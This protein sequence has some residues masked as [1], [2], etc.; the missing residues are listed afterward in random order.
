MNFRKSVWLFSLIGLVSF[1]GVNE[2]QAQ[3]YSN[4]FT[5]AS[6]CP[7]P[8]NVP[9][10]PA[11]V[12]GSP[13]TRQGATCTVTANVF[14]STTL[15]NTATLS[16]TNY[17]EF[18]LTAN[19]GYKM[20]I[21]SLS[22]FRQGSGTAPN[23]LEVRYSTD[24]FAT[25]TAW[26]AAP[27]TPTSGSAITWNF[28]DFL[29]RHGGSVK[30]RFYPYGTQRADLAAGTAATTGTFRLDDV[31]V[32]GGV[33][34]DPEYTITGPFPTQTTTY[35]TAATPTAFTLSGQYLSNT[36]TIFP[37][38]GYEISLAENSGYSTNW[39]EITPS[40]FAIPTTTLYIRLAANTAPGDY[41]LSISTAVFPD[42][43][44]FHDLSS[45]G[46]VLIKNLTLAGAAA[47][48]KIYDRNTAAAITGTLT[49]VENGDVLTLVGGG[50]FADF[51]VDDDIAVTSNL[52][53]NGANAA[54]Y[55]FTQPTGLS[56]DIT[57][58]D[59]T[60]VD[61]EAEDK[62]FDGNTDA[63]ITGTLSGVISP[64]VV[65]FVGTGTFASSAVGEN[66]PVTSTSTIT[67][68]SSNYNLVQP[69]GL[70]ANI[71]EEAL[72]PQ[73]ITF[74]PLANVTYGDANFNLTAT[75]SSLLT[76]TYMSSNTDVATVSGNVVTIVGAGTT[77]ITAEQDGNGTYEE[78]TPVDQT[79]TVD[80][81]AITATATGND[82]TY[83]GNNSATLSGTLNGVINS[84]DV[85]FIGT[86]TFAS[87]DV[88]DGILITSTS[89][90]GGAD[91]GNY[92][93]TQ[94]TG[95]SADI[96]VKT[97]TANS[98]T[99]NNKV[100]DGNTDAAISNLTLTG[101]I[102]GDDVTA[103]GGGTFAS[104]DVNNNIPVTAALTLTGADAG[105]YTLT[106]PI[107]LSA[108]ITALGLTL[109]GLSG[110]N[111]VYDRTNTAS[112]SG[113]A[114]LGGFVLSDDVFAIGTPT[115]TFNNQFVGSNKPITVSGYS[116]SGSDAG[117][118][119]LAQPTGIT[120]NITQAFVTISGAVA[121][122]KPFDGNTNAVITGTLSGVISPDVV[123]LIG[124]GT[125]ASSAVGNGIAVTSTSTL[126]GTHGS[127]YA[128]NP[129]PTGLTA[130]IT[131]GPTVL[132]VGDLSIIGFNVN[133][134]DNFA[135][136]CWVD[137]AN[138]TYIKFTDNAF[139]AATSANATNN[140]RGGEQFVIWRN[141]GATIP[142]GTV[143]TIQDNTSSA[144][145]NHGT[146]VSGN[147]N[148]LASGGDNIFAYQGAATSGSTPDFASNSNPTTFNGT[149][150]FGLQLQGSGG[151]ST[152]TWLSS[153]TANTNNSYLPTQLNVPNATVVL[154]SAA[155]R[156]QYTGPRDNQLSMAGYKAQVTNSGYWTTGAA[157]GVITLNTASFTLATGP[158]AA[159]LS[160]SATIC[161]GD[162]AS[163]TVDITGGSAPYVVTLSDGT[164]QFSVD[165]Y[166][167][168]NSIG[169]APTATATYT[170]VSVVD[171]NA[172]AST[173]NSGSATITVNNEYP[174]YVDAD[175]DGYG[176]GSAVNLCAADANTP[177][178]GYAVSGFDCN[179]S[180]A[181]I[182]PF[183]IEI[184][185]NG[186]DDDCD[187]ATDETGTV[188]TTLLPSSCGT[189][190]A[191]IG[192]LIGIQTVGGHPITGYRIRVTN[193]A[194]VQ[195][196]E[197]NV[198]HFTMPQFPIYAYATTYTVE[199][200]LQRA[201]IWQASWGAACFVSTP[202]I[203]EEGGAASVSPSQCGI[204]LPKINTLIATTSIAGVTGYRFR[205][206]NL[207]DVSGPN[208]VQTI[209]RTQN[210]FSLQMLTRYN[211]GTTYRIEVAVKTT[212]DFSGF[213]AP[214]QVSSPAV[215]SLVN[216]GGTVAS[217]TTT[218]AATSV[219]GATQYRFQI[220]RQSDNASTTIDRNSNYFIFNSVPTSAFTA[221]AL[222]SV[223]VAVLTSG[224]WS[225]FGDACEITAPGGTAKG[226]INSTQAIALE[227]TSKVSAYPNPFSSA[228][229]IDATGN[230]NVSVKVYD[231]L[232][233]MI[234]SKTIAV[235]ELAVQSL[236]IDYPSG[237][238][239]VIVNQDGMVKT[240]RVVKR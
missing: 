77:T 143:I 161:A 70:T 179:D 224:A 111:K 232:G 93:L 64:D 19:T 150:L 78:A 35:G 28:P 169:L 199:I 233:R 108:N 218:V 63:V 204:T 91:A 240:L 149:L 210:W 106:Q 113:T 234:E 235:S 17:I 34:M 134:P 200:Q 18:S 47:Q 229:H 124:T 136:V 135:F 5:G 171:S 158:T 118:Y 36:V 191:S 131:P 167:S 202:A 122:N 56:A 109:T 180:V 73:T 13:L 152:A 117:N 190:L 89:T 197:K 217:G 20:G 98:A 58:K 236:G 174:F 101:A 80:P 96:T 203:L 83:D 165:E 103:I 45:T 72:Q 173:N 10:F 40:V 95:L 226:A 208:A 195:V 238:Y 48:N 184:P 239:N 130:N 52:T 41:P 160:G 189:T 219:S 129:Q 148:G 178:A 177:P 43:P 128:I 133:T 116:L 156:G 3:L 194:Q 144:G 100:Y 220:T 211:Y 51:N 11:N 65:N 209:D 87:V 196:I 104:E 206:T 172:L 110:V 225:P 216:C 59:L 181:S 25:F 29:V 168:G 39:V 71:Y 68:D 79:L 38:T 141:N 92:T 90:L 53:L 76:V 126:G 182:H 67:G 9:T 99:A 50:T 97:L 115:A 121:Q 188:T 140:A 69:T 155:S 146:I 60:V 164:D 123:T 112:L 27:N 81:K 42:G 214:C 170:L 230:Q 22:F 61:A 137:I 201:G 31:T 15:N 24:N 105:N 175:G 132:N 227:S 151:T 192:S 1:F 205:V 119:T 74:D 30:F 221:G 7:T 159:V 32:T 142:A 44:E 37:A 23:R 66:I 231:M 176:T 88:A 33:A 102:N 16:E 207:T 185:Y 107:G 213:G 84:D 85:T 49:G 57:A 154:A 139:L 193:G 120:A 125:F 14:N 26:G 237:V 12:T 21:Q 145:T 212:G 222:Y 198:P 223:R 138:G 62:L 4:V 2:A 147:L 215:P 228:F 55:S 46:T 82:K 6:T 157:A 86:G 166:V 75:A 153:G 163:L 54:Y 183:A 187:G 8:G 127:N 94:P 114:V 186:V 162:S